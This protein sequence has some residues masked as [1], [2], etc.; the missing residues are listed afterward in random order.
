MKPLKSEINSANLVSGLARIKSKTRFEKLFFDFDSKESPEKA[1]TEARDFADKIERFYGAKALL[2]FSGTKGCHVYVW[3]HALEFP[4]KHT[5]LVKET[6]RRLQEK[7]LKGLHYETVDHAVIGDLARLSRVPYSIHEKSGRLCEPPDPSCNLEVCRKNG[8]SSQRLRLT[9]QE[10]KM[11]LEAQERRRNLA[12]PFKGVKGA[13]KQVQVLVEKAQ[14]GEKIEHRERLAIACEL[15][16][17]NKTDDEI[18]QVFSN[19]DDFNES[20]IRYF[21]EHVRSRD[22]RPFKLAT[23]EASK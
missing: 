1:I 23:L 7:L 21:V 15:I 16:A 19:Q 17:A 3:L 12:T 6:Y 4:P 22:Y 18:I 9:L 5:L 10:A 14:R 13:R 2:V 11:A 20:K 8:L